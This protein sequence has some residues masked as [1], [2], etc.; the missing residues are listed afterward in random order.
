[1]DPSGGQDV[2]CYGFKAWEGLDRWVGTVN[3]LTGRRGRIREVSG[4]SEGRRQVDWFEERGEGGII[5]KHVI[6]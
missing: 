3:I 6:G 2:G 1:M 5:W 4:C